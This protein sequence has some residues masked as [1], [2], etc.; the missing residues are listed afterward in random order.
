[1]RPG[2][3]YVFPPESRAPQVHTAKEDA[4][5][6]RA[7]CGAGRDDGVIRILTEEELREEIEWMFT[8]TERS[9]QPATAHY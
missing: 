9:A 8:Y 4:E 2:P 3:K 1:M 5:T 6:L 7:R